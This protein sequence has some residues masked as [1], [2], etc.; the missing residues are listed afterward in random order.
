[1]KKTLLFISIFLLLIFT[2]RIHSSGVPEEPILRMEM[3]MHSSWITSIAVDAQNQFI[4]TGSQ[5]KTVR[6]WEL[7]TGRLIKIFRPPIGEG[8]VGMIFAV[9]ILTRWKNDCLWGADKKWER[10]ILFH[11]PVRS[12]EWKTCPKNRRS[13]SIIFCALPIQRMAGFLWWEWEKMEESEFIVLQIIPLPERTGTTEM[14]FHG[15]DFDGNGRLVT[16][17]KDGFIRLY[18]SDFKLITKKKA[19]DG[20]RPVPVSFSPDGSSIAVTFYDDT[21]LNG[22]LDVLS[23]KDLSHQ[24]SP[25][26]RGLAKGYFGPVCWSTDGKFLYAGKGTWIP[27]IIR[28]WSEGGKGP[29]KDLGAAESDLT[30]LLSLKD[31]G[32]VFASAYPSFGVF[33]ANDKKVLH[34]TPPIADYRCGPKEFLVSKNGDRIQFCYERLGKSPARFSVIE[35]SLKTLPAHLK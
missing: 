35:R 26:M 22:K 13:F 21:M 12:G 17:S 25:D 11:L 8:P 1:M 20:F 28:K 2:G 31:G 27:F 10:N 3:G 5:D 6:L 32:I 9:A 7:S 16:V 24:Y 23:G 34:M 15:V 33:D 19:P 14:P 4:V 29:Y 18:G 30:G